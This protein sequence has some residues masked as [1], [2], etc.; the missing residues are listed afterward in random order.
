MTVSCLFVSQTLTGEQTLLDD[1]NSRL[2]K[3]YRARAFEDADREPLV[4]AGNAENHP[5]EAESAD[6][7]RHWENMFSDPTKVRLTLLAPNGSIAGSANIQAGMIPRADGTQNIGVGVHRDHRNK[8]LG[9]AMLDVFEAE[10]KRRGVPRILS[11]V[12][13]SK[14]FALSFATK[15]GYKEIGRRIMS[16]RELNSYDPAVWRESL[17]R[18]LKAGIRMRSFSEILDERD[19]AGK[20]RFWHELWEAE[21]PMWDDI[22]FATPTPHWPFDR[23]YKM[24]VKSGQLLLDL[25]LIAY[26][27]DQ[28]A[29]FTTTGDR[30]KKDGWTWMTGVAR[31]QR[32]KGIAMAIKVEVLARAKAKG[33]RA[34]C[35]VNDEPNKAMRGVN[36]KLGYQPVPDHV[37]LEK[38]L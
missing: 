22:P 16:Y 25:S 12:S 33:L 18:A 29:G 4:E 8:G 15:R 24:A 30:Q 19:E 23:F 17:E 26:A 32:G 13:A 36:I 9:T 27:G 14:P 35:T 1:L 3:G 5:M 11:G 31:D 21:G 20:E 38:H 28:I 7:W 6:E 34:M 37:E 10:A 2:P